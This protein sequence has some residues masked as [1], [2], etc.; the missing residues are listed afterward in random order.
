MMP[1]CIDCG[2]KTKSE[3]SVRCRSCYDIKRRSQY[4]G[5]MICP[6]C[7][8]RY[9]NYKA[10]VCRACWLG[11][12]VA[13]EKIC[14]VC[15]E[16]KPLD[17]FK[18]A[19]GYKYGVSS[20]CRLCEN[21]YTRNQRFK[22]RESYLNKIRRRTLKKYGLTSEEYQQMAMNGCH[23]CGKQCKS[24][25]RL[26]IDHDHKNNVT[27]GLLCGTCNNGLGRFRDDIKLLE[28]AIEYLRKYQTALAG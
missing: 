26:A 11:P 16:S 13:T 21:A 7:G 28:R 8:N 24:G 6:G 12:D 17:H 19:N 9:W 25:R 18:K 23:I 5:S 27:R 4:A 2:N 15:G 14:T 22:N 3:K 1:K 20:W 10:K